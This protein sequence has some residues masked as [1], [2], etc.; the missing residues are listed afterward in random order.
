[1]SRYILSPQA[2]SDIREIRK[3]IARNNPSAAQ[4]LVELIRQKCKVIADFPNVG[5]SYANVASSLR[6]IPSGSY[7]I[8]YRPI[9]TGIKV[10]RVISGYRNLEAEFLG[11]EDS[12][13]E[14]ESG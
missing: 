12:I 8:L 14:D 1:M 10:A 4:H 6:G 7:L 2:K 11:Q 13:S 5:R 3:Y 9:E